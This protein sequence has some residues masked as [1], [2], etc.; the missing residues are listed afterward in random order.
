MAKQIVIKLNK[1]RFGPLLDQ[2]KE[3]FASVDAKTYSE[4]VG[5]IIFGI[6]WLT[7]YKY[8]NGK[9]GMDMVR[10]AINEV[11]GRNFSWSEFCVAFNKRFNEW[12]RDSKWSPVVT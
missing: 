9:T 10:E 12:V 4:E 6:Y 8:P 1:K 2:I 3:C 5:K 11:S 7:S